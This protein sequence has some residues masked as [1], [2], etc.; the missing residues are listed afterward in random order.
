MGGDT[1]TAMARVVYKWFEYFDVGP[2]NRDTG[3]YIM[4]G[5]MVNTSVPVRLH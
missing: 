1:S 5:E 2:L 3:M 4:T